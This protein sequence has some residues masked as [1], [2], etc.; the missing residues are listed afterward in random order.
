[1]IKKI[2]AVVSACAVVASLLAGCGGES[3][4]EKVGSDTQA[5]QPK[6]E[7]DQQKAEAP[8]TYKVGETVDFDGLHITVQGAKVSKGDQFFKPQKGKFIYVDVLI[9]NKTDKAAAISSLLN[10]KLVDADGV[11]YTIA[12]VPDLQ[13]QLDGEVG[14]G[15]KM[16]GQA[17]FDVADSKYYEFIF[18]NPFTTGQAIWKLED[19]K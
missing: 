14:P 16:K 3:T 2:F 1:M 4:I 10:L 17:A 13:G 8:K 6:G 5:D 12:I 15:R 19:V 18:E 9:E 11:Q 7:A